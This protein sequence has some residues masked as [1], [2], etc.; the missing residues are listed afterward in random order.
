MI[1]ATLLSAFCLATLVA[2]LA[3]VAEPP[4]TTQGVAV[5]FAPWTGAG[6]AFERVARAGGE[7][8]RGGGFPFVAVAAASS[9]DFAARIRTQGA[10]LLLDPQGL[11]GCL[12][13]TR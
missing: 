11:G 13:W 5:V 2:P 6:E 9:P 8:V 7:I 12:D 1:R 4:A 10:W 3:L